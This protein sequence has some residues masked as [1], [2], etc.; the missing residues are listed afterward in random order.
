MTKKSKTQEF[1]ENMTNDLVKQ[2]QMKK[3]FN[4]FIDYVKVCESIVQSMSGYEDYQATWSNLAVETIEEWIYREWRK[5]NRHK[6]REMEIH[7]TI[8]QLA[9]F[10]DYLKRVYKPIENPAAQALLHLENGLMK[11]RK[12]N[13]KAA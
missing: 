3:R 1:I 13:K 6:D 12:Y 5:A 7:Q 11:K 8:L 2:N 10:Y 4:A 9:A